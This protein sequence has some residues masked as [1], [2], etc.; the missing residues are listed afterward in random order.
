MKVV[1]SVVNYNTKDLTKNCL[2]TI[3]EQAWK[4]EVEVW[5][6]DNASKDGS[7]G[8]LKRCFPQIHLIVNQKN[9]GFGKAHNQVFE[10]AKGDFFLVLNSDTQ[11]GKGVIDEMVSFMDKG[12][13]DIAS[14]KILGFDGKLQ[15]NGGDLPLGLALLSWLFNLEALG[16]KMNFHRNEP[17]YYLNARAV[18][19]VSG[20]L[21][22]ITQKAL[23]RLKGFNERYFMY[24]EDTEFCLRAQK[25]GFSVMIN[26]VVSVKH[27]SGGSLANPQFNQ[28]RG[29]YRG[30]LIFYRQHFGFLRAELVRVLIYLSTLLRILTFAMLGKFK[31]SFSYARVIASI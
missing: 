16:V 12:N 19:W 27:L 21:M 24:F 8:V 30:L 14:C 17:S 26:P 13:C 6:V 4:H 22:M 20:S 31:L 23:E 5:L 9:L 1:V 25:A 10:K 28:W 29:E 15:P 7:A 18:G 2:K 3:F 11:V